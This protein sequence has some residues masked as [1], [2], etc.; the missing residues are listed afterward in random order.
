MWRLSRPD[1]ASALDDPEVKR[2]LPRYVD[3]VKNVE[4]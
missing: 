3:V 1:A 2:S 4:D